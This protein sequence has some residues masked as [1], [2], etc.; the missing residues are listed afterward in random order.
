MCH[1]PGL[2]PLPGVHHQGHQHAR[3]SYQQQVDQGSDQEQILV[4]DIITIENFA[5]SQ[6]FSFIFIHFSTDHYKIEAIFLKRS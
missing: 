6:F 2:P 1:P 5:L 4:T 3:H